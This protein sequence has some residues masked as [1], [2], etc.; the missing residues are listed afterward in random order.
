MRF[1][2]GTEKASIKM[3]VD[4]D[5]SPSENEWHSE[6]EIILAPFLIFSE[7]ELSRKLEPRLLA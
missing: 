5:L 2:L 4:A 1:T 3:A 7:K 6:S